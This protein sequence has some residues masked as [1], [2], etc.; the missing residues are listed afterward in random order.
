VL[1]AIQQAAQA[2]VTRR[3]PVAVCGEM[4]GEPALAALL[5]GLGVTELSMAP[6]R[7][8]TV[9]EALASYRMADLRATA[10]RAAA[11]ETVAAA[12]RALAELTPLTDGYSGA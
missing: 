10:E 6:S 2:G 3:I 11:A 7:I 9:K 8:P 5:V 1:R 4:A 12:D